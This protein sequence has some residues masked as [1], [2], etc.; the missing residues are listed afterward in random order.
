MVYLIEML[1]KHFLEAND[2]VA[3]VQRNQGEPLINSIA[4]VVVIKINRN[5]TSAKCI[6]CLR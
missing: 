2:P 1:T 3:Q 6:G 5:I 4:T